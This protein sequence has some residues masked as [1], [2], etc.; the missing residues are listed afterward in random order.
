M[1]IRD[2]FRYP[3]I[4]ELSGH[5]TPLASQVDQGPAEGEADLAP[6]QRRFFGQVHAFTTITTSPSYFS[7]KRIQY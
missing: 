3:T 6:I 2:L 4:Q 7:V 1:T 5:I